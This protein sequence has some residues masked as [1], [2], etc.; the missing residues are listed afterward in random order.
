VSAGDVELAGDHL[1]ASRFLEAHSGQVRW[2]P[3]LDRWF[4]W[5][6][7]WWQ[8]DR[9]ERV[10]DLALEVI[11]GL[12]EWVAEASGN[13]FRHRA[14]HY[15]AS[16]RAGR[17]EAM[18][19]VARP[20][21]VVGVE[22]LDQRP[23]L[24]ACLNG[25]VDLRTGELHPAERSHLLTRGVKV[26]YDPLAQSDLWEQ[27]LET[28]FDRD[29]DLIAYVQ[30]SIGYAATGTIREHV[31]LVYHGTGANGKSTLLG[32]I[33][34]LLGE[35]ALTAPEGLFTQVQHEPHPERIA[36]LRGRRLVS[37]FELENRAT[38]AEGLVKT[39]TGG[40]R[41][42]AREMYGRRFDFAPSHKLVIVTNHRPRVRG[43]DESIWRR[44]RL[45]PFE[46]TIRP[47]D[48]DG[49][50]RQRLVQEHG[51]AVLGWIVQGAVAWYSEGLGESRK[52]TQ[53]TAAYRAE[54]DTFSAFL[55][56]RT[57][58]SPRARTPVGE[59]WQAWREW[60]EASGERP[61]RK[62]DFSAALESHGIEL[63]TYNHQRYARDLISAGGYGGLIRTSSRGNDIE[64]FTDETSGDPREGLGSWPDGSP[65]ALPK[66]PG[67]E[68]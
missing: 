2:S 56:D 63:E 6:D 23:Y 48:Q 65:Y 16:S 18:L 54:Q 58:E 22:E 47:E 36:A 20:R 1:N 30:R 10:Q 39:L 37:C 5:S 57:A 7:A 59:L 40:D 34:D 17:V 4:V 31:A 50:L 12:R 46:H 51:P 55:E 8:E 35:L 13:E 28:T 60:S 67:R 9:T 64:K 41:L 24:L 14:A 3:E 25:E 19:Q 52:V 43:T 66:S 61:G 44:L 62:Q 32:A 33:Q 21:L 53:A 45:V 49:T 38:L 11:D 29:A 42:S 15:A 27:F 26:E 68:S